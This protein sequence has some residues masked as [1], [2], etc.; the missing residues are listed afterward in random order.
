[1]KILELERSWKSFGRKQR[2]LIMRDKIVK[3]MDLIMVNDLRV[4]STA[5]SKRRPKVSSREL[6]QKQKL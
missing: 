1:M 5:I 6:P 4:K 2:I 3:Y